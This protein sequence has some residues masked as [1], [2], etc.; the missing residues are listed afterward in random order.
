M[1]VSMNGGYTKVDDLQ[2]K[3]QQ[4]MIW[5]WGYP[6]LGNTLSLNFKKKCW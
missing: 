5:A 1:E 4:K 6:L 3:I 2:W